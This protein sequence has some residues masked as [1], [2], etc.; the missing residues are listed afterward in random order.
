M[1]SKRSSL[2][3]IT[4]IKESKE[5]TNSYITIG[6]TLIVIILLIVFA[7]RPTITKIVNIRKEIK[8]KG[9]ISKLLDDRIQTL[10]SLDNDFQESKDKFEFVPLVFPESERYVL[11]LS[12]IE[13]IVNR[14]SFKLSSLTFDKYDGESYNISTSV[15]KPTS[16]RITVL[17]LYSNFVNLLKDLESLPMYIVVDSV[18]FGS[19]KASETNEVS[20]SL[21]LRIYNIKEPKFY[22][23]K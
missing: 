1:E 18:S 13:P 3:L 12:N 2:G 9:R 17:G 23:L 14:N 4:T 20:Y 16:L 10:S 11:I 6:F 19:S 15:L 21:N 5:K 8:E 22:S 7:I